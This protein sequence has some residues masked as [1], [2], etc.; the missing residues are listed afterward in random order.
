MILWRAVQ[1]FLGAGMSVYATVDTTEGAPDA[2]SDADPD[3][4][5]MIHP[6]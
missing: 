5:T 2:D 1:G 3:S 6:Q 4:P